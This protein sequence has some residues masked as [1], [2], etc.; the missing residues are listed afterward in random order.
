MSLVQIGE[1]DGR[2]MLVEAKGLAQ[3]HRTGSW[4][5]QEYNLNCQTPSPPHHIMLQGAVCEV[6]GHLAWLK[7]PDGLPPKRRMVGDPCMK[8]AMEGKM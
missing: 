6:K 8:N 4:Q 5:S 3:E 7:F 2:L 1:D